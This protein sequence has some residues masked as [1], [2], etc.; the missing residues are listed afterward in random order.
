MIHELALKLDA[1]ACKYKSPNVSLYSFGLEGRG[2]Q[3]SLFPL[4][5]RSPVRDAFFIDPSP[6]SH[7]EVLM[8]CSQQPKPLGVRGPLTA[9]V[10]AATLSP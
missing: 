9:P 1:R 6:F 8:V 7:S 5:A 2:G 3:C 10:M 4:P